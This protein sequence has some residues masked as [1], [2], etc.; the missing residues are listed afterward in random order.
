M[1][2]ITTIRQVLAL[3]DALERAAVRRYEVLGACMRRVG[4]ADLGRI[5]EALAHEERQHVES[6]EHLTQASPGSGPGAELPSMALPETFEI[7]DAA[8]AA[9][10]TPYKALGIAVRGEE[11]AFTFWV[12]VASEAANTEVRA[13]AEGMARQ[14]L[15]HAA[16]LRL[17]RRR[18]Y[19][20]ERE[21]HQPHPGDPAD[22]AAVRSSIG[23][24]ERETAATLSDAAA[25]LEGEVDPALLRL[26][27]GFAAGICAVPAAEAEAANVI[28]HAAAVGPLGILFEAA[29]SVEKLIEQYLILLR[30]SVDPD[31]LEEASRRCEKATATV[32]R[33]NDSLYALEPT[34]AEF[35]HRTPSAMQ[36]AGRPQ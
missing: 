14:E 8:A 35:A 5:F 18:A 11:H 34:L 30:R 16:K 33:L 21:Q 24:Y 28:R 20:A 12:Y 19:H 4:H 7:G 36:V 22:A 32:S 13:Q 1:V 25:Q 15:V 9:R 31:E 27:R 2:L 6:V 17:E 29:G 3:A 23:R 26:I 10:L